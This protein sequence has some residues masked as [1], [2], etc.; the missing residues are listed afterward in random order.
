MENGTAVHPQVRAW[1]ERSV[2][3]PYISEFCSRLQRSRY[4]ASTIHCYLY[5]VAPAVLNGRRFSGGNR[6]DEAMP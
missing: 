6:I 3:Q 1:L 4:H 2:L 5:C